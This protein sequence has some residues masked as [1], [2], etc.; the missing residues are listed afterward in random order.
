MPDNLAW[1]PRDPSELS[2]DVARLAW[3]DR[4]LAWPGSRLVMPLPM[5]AV[6]VAALALHLSGAGA[7]SHE[8]AAHRGAPTR[9]IIDQRVG[10]YVASVW[11][12]AEVGTGP[13]YVVLESATGVTFTPPSAVRVGVAPVS[14]RLPEIMHDAHSEPVR[15]GARF[16]ADA[17]F[18]RAERWNVRVVIDGAA[19]GGE[20]ASPV[21]V[22]PNASL[23]PF[24]LVLSS[25]PFVVMGVVWWRAAD[26]RRRT[27]ALS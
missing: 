5:F 23:G 2:S 22:K 6:A 3:V 15:S 21:E 7:H 1:L 18:D 13:L 26:A 12:D 25:L 20:I 19:G 24:A 17:V 10:P 9:I 27:N 8:M 4:F 14:G 16:M 11:T